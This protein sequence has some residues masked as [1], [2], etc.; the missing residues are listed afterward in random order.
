MNNS[1]MLNK[2]K[3]SQNIYFIIY[4][5]KKYRP[6]IKVILIFDVFKIKNNSIIP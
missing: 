6:T 3:L 5:L 1:N 2:F 4:K